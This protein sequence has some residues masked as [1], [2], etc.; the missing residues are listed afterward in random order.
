MN[1]PLKSQLS[2]M[3]PS[4]GAGAKK[5]SK[6]ILDGR[7]VVT[8]KLIVFKNAVYP[9]HNIASIEFSDNTQI[10]AKVM[11]GWYWV[12]LVVGIATIPM[13]I[14]VVIV[15]AAIWLFYNHSKNRVKIREEYGLQIETNAGSGV[16]LL[17]AKKEFVL[18][19]LEKVLETLNSEDPEPVAFDFR[20]Y[21]IDDRSITIGQSIGSALVSGEVVGNVST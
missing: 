20:T 5:Q 6:I 2:Q 16:V 1:P 12:V 4:E 7:L 8:G 18:R 19:V 3:L 10:S 11:P 17:S 9:L 14:G 15:L 13:G 21:S